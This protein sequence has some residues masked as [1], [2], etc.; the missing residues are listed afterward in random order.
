MALGAECDARLRF[1][2]RMRSEPVF[3]NLTCNQWSVVSCCA[4]SD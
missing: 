1:V 3:S 4:G 2:V